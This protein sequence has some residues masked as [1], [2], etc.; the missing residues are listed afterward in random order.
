MKLSLHSDVVPS[1]TSNVFNKSRLSDS[2]NVSCSPLW[3]LKCQRQRSSRSRDNKDFFL[4]RLKGGK[5]SIVKHYKQI[6]FKDQVIYESQKL[7]FSGHNFE[8]YHFVGFF[9]Y[10][11]QPLKARSVTYALRRCRMFLTSLNCKILVMYHVHLYFH[12]AEIC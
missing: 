10:L 6:C 3:T 2:R 5:I 12:P 7:C 8:Y 1:F 9:F 4:H 11:L